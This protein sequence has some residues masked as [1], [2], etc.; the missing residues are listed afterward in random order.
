MVR[1]GSLREAHEANL[2]RQ[3]VAPFQA[4]YRQVTANGVEQLIA[5]SPLAE[6]QWTMQDPFGFACRFGLVS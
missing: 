6:A 1:G 4:A 5:D 2:S 3:F